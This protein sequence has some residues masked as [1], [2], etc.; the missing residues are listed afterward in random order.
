MTCHVA[1]PHLCW[2]HQINTGVQRK[3]SPNCILMKG[4]LLPVD[5]YGPLSG[6]KPLTA[7]VVV[8][9]VQPLQ[10]TSTSPSQAKSKTWAALRLTC[11]SL[12]PLWKPRNPPVFNRPRTHHFLSQSKQSVHEGHQDFPVKILF[13][14]LNSHLKTYIHKTH[15][16]LT[17]L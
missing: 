12:F 14:R 11:S 7:V 6:G 16:T 10:H 8:S 9:A 4:R 2:H 3:R 5:C 17:P 15:K 13:T 1:V